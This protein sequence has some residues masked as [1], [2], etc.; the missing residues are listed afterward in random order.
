MKKLRTVLL[1]DDEQVDRMLYSRVIS[2][3]QL[4]ENLVCLDAGDAAL[5]YLRRST[6]EGKS[7]DAIFLDINMPRMNGFE[8]LEAAAEELGENFT[9]MVIIMLTTSLDPK[10]IERA[11]SIESI[12]EY[13]HKPLTVDNVKLVA[14]RVWKN[15][16]ND[17]N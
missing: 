7:V 2:R 6:T 10:D 9:S 13:I 5:D 3:S 8:F 11:K 16:S 15:T 12:K 1:V 17:H 14:K 4:V